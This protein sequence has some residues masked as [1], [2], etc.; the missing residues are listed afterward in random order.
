MY[1]AKGAKGVVVAASTAEK[2]VRGVA[3]GALELAAK[4]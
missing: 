3:K 2:G 1:V 4:V